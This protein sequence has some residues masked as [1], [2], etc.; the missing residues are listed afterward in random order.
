[1]NQSLS[2]A[3]GAL[4]LAEDRAAF[5]EFLEACYEHRERLLIV[6]QA[7][8]RDRDRSEDAVS[9]AIIKAA[10]RRHQL[11]DVNKLF[12]WL[13]RIVTHQCIDMLRKDRREVPAEFSDE[14]DA[15]VHPTSGRFDDPGYRLELAASIETV[16][17]A[18]LAVRPKAFRD[19]LIRYYY[20]GLGYAEMCLDLNLPAG[21]VK[22]RLNRARHVLLRELEQR[23]VSAADFE[24]IPQLGVWPEILHAESAV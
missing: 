1:M 11:R 10:R 6:A 20:R 17:D 24:T 21:T 22:S 4:A 5:A 8:L 7:R 18:M 15:S 13:A 23:G 2:E 3:Q 14:D 16:L 12:P 19:V 9:D